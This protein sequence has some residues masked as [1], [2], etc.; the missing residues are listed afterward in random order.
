MA[1][2]R[3]SFGKYMELK[4]PYEFLACEGHGCAL[5]AFF[6]I[7]KAKG[8]RPFLFVDVQDTMVANCYFMRVPSQ[9]FDHVFRPP[10]R[11]LGIDHPL[12]FEQVVI[13]WGIILPGY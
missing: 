9:I 8:D 1:D 4:T 12:L 2:S 10:E 6:V 7:L 13:Y 5:S 3:K 11:G